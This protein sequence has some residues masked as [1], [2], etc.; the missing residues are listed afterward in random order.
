M[1]SREAQEAAADAK[2]A[3]SREE[4]SGLLNK[5]GD[6]FSKVG[7]TMHLDKVGDGL[8]NVGKAMQLDKVPHQIRKTKRHL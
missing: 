7:K 2:K 4:S 6:G 1:L 5:V 3:L 8:S